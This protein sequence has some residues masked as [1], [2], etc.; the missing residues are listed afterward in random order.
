LYSF[1]S[2]ATFT[3]CIFSG[4]SAADGG[5]AYIL[6]DDSNAFSFASCTFQNNTASGQ[7]GGVNGTGG[8]PSIT[9]CVISGNNAQSGGGIYL[10]PGSNE[11]TSTGTITDC[12]IEN[13]TATDGGGGIYC[14]FYSSPAINGCTIENNTG[15]VDG[16][17]IMIN[18]NCNPTITGCTITGNSTTEVGLGLG[19]GAIMISNHCSPNITDCTISGNTTAGTPGGGGI[20]CMD[21]SPTIINTTFDAADTIVLDDESTLN[22]SGACC[23]DGLCWSISEADC[24]AVGG[25]FT[26][27]ACSADTAC[28]TPCS[29][30]VDNDGDIDIQDLLQM[31]TDWGACP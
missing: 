30:D 2:N 11:G 3:N 9:N 23:Y 17:G 29:S 10:I 14:Y 24:T 15:A 7:G 31:L 19:G 12:T 4:N 13:N 18:D 20:Y 1:F 8:N 27:E 6:A 28:P 26:A 16:G 25:S 5:G 21:S 22:P